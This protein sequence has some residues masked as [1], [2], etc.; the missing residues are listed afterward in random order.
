[1]ET[2]TAHLENARTQTEDSEIVLNFQ[3]LYAKQFLLHKLPPPPPQVWN[4]RY[5]DLEESTVKTQVLSL[6]KLKKMNSILIKRNDLP[7]E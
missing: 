6:V 1:M 3:T 5:Q 2:R 7:L 4:S